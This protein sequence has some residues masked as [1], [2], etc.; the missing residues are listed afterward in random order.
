MRKRAGRQ[1]IDVIEPPETKE[2]APSFPSRPSE[3]A[4]LGIP[5]GIL[6]G[7]GPP[8]CLA[9]YYCLSFEPSRIIIIA[10]L[11]MLLWLISVV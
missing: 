8:D 10:W 6:A 11:R 7:I 5:D 2:K 9:H 4:I 1:P 3:G